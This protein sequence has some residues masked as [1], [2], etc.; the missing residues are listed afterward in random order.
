MDKV[1]RLQALGADPFVPGS[2]IPRTHLAGSLQRELESLPAGSRAEEASYGCV[3][4]AGRVMSKRV[5]G[6]MAFCG[7]EDPSGT[8]QLCFREGEDRETVGSPGSSESHTSPESSESSGSPAWSD[9]CSSPNTNDASISSALSP[10]LPPPRPLTFAH[11]F[12]EGLLDV[13]DVVTALGSVRRTPR[14]ELSLDVSACTIASKCLRPLP[15]KRRGLLDPDARLRARH[16]DLLTRPGARRPLLARAAALKSIRAR[17]DKGGFVEVETPVLEAQ[18]GGAEARPF[19]THHEA[20]K[21]DLVLR[22]APELHL[23]RL[24]VGGLE[25]VYEIG[26][27]FR[28][29]GLSARHNPEF[30]SLEVYQAW[31]DY[32]DMM[33]LTEDLLRQAALAVHGTAK[34]PYQ[35]QE[36][37]FESPFRRVTMQ[38]SVAEALGVDFGRYGFAQGRSAQVVGSR[39]DL[40]GAKQDLLRALP[41]DAPAGTR[42]QVSS[43]P[44]LGLLLQTVFEACVEPLLLQ[45]TFVTLLPVEVSPLAAAHRS[46]ADVTE[47][48]ELFAA[49]R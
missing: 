18:A 26:R 37:D 27:N 49:G 21:R 31:A 2:A 45:P 38:Q 35:G 25:R 24:V 43:A 28:N 42:Q 47:R 39:H 22:I 44:S 7:L 17:L 34:L 5:M 32:R 10:N 23:K 3:A 6:S 19:R 48:F 20:L 8:L 9:S 33:A 1:A 30:S 41:A 12:R 4:V 29:E 14:G 40:A 16:V 13:G 46:L 15:D 11:L 36:L